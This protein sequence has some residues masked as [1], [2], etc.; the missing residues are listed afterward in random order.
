MEGSAE[1]DWAHEFEIG[2]AVELAGAEL[3]RIGA[4]DDGLIAGDET[5]LELDGFAEAGLAV[6]WIFGGKYE[7][8]GRNDVFL[9]E[10]DVESAGNEV[11]K[12]EA[13]FDQ[14]DDGIEIGS[15][16]AVASDDGAEEAFHGVELEGE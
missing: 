13:G 6:I 8:V 10:G 4:N 12:A 11:A 9:G 16:H 15:G 3:M 5:A 1:V 7:S 2:L 14:G